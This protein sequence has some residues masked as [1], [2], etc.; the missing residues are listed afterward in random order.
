MC[1]TQLGMMMRW[2]VRR[3]PDIKQKKVRVDLRGKGRRRRREKKNRSWWALKD[4]TV[5]IYSN[6]LNRPIC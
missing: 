4:Y 3:M 5:V 1:T 6:F 2:L